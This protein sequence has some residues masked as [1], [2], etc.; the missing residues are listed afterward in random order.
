[1][2]A[3]EI[4]ELR[5]A[6]VTEV[7]A[8]KE[9][10]TNLVFIYEKIR[11]IKVSCNHCKGV[12]R[13]VYNFVINNKTK[14]TM[15]NFK[16]KTGTVLDISADGNHIT[17][18][19]LTDEKAI[20]VLRKSKA[21]IKF[22]VEYPEGWENLLFFPSVPKAS[23]PI[24]PKFAPKKE[25]APEPKAKPEQKPEPKPEPK[26]KKVGRPAKKKKGK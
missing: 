3:K 24:L 22:F 12:L 26:P 6:G 17:N 19:N 5:Q 8:S 10:K 13:E 21:F 11:G 4:E 16:L 15:S 23:P 2:F 9:H 20:S 18:D 1:M 7:L 14:F 25:I